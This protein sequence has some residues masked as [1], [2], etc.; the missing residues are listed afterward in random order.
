MIRSSIALVILLGLGIGVAQARIEEPPA[1][2]TVV[3]W[4]QIRALYE[5]HRHTATLDEDG[6]YVARNPKQGWTIRFDGRGFLVR[7]DE[8]DWT[9]GLELV[10]FGVSGAPQAIQGAAPTVTAEHEQVRYEWRPDLEE[11]FV[12]DTRGLEH[13]WTVKRR[14]QGADEGLELELAVRGGL[15]PEV[16]GPDDSAV[17]F[18]D[19]AG[20]AVV[21]YAGLKGW[22]ADGRALSS[23]MA[24]SAEGG[25]TILVDDREARYP[26]TVDP[27]AVQTAYIK[28]SNTGSIDRFGVSVSISGDTLAVGAPRED[29]NGV[30]VNPNTQADNSA[31]DSG[32][33]YVFQRTVGLWAQQAYIKASNTE[34]GDWFGSS[35]ALSGDTLVVG[36]PNED[37]AGNS[38]K[39]GGAVYLF[40]RT[41]ELWVQQDFTSGL[42]GSRFGGSVALYGDT[43]LNLAVGARYENGQGAVYVFGVAGG[44]LVG[45]KRIG[46]GGPGSQF[47][48]S[49]AL[50]ED[51]LAVGSPWGGGHQQGTV[52]IFTRANG[53]RQSATLIASN[54]DLAD[55]F[56]QSVAIDGDTLA[57]GAT[58]E[59][60][61]GVG[62][63]SVAQLNNSAHDSGAVYVF[64]RAGGLWVQQ[65]YVKASNPY[66]S[67]WFGS[68]V[69]LSGDTLA[70]G[71]YWEDSN[72]V[73]VN[74][75]AQ[76]GNSRTDSGAVYVFQRTGGLWVQ[77][78]FI[79]ASNTDAN[80]QF[81]YSIAL[82]VD[83]LVVGADGEDSNGV[84]INSGIQA[85]NSAAA[86]GA[87]YAFEFCELT[88]TAVT[89]VAPSPSFPG[90]SFQVYFMVSNVCGDTILGPVIVSNGEGGECTASGPLGS[91]WLTRSSAGV[92]TITATYEGDGFFL[93]S[94]GKTSHT[95]VI[96][97]TTTAGQLL[98]APSP[99]GIGYEVAFTVTSNFGVPT[100]SVMVSDGEASNTCLVSAGY[101]V[102][103]STTAGAK[104]ITIDYLGDG[105]FAP[106]SDSAAQTVVPVNTTTSIGYLNPSTPVA[107]QPYEVSYSI[108]S[109]GGVP[110]G[111]VTVS[112]GVAS[113]TCAVADPSC[114]LTT[115][116]AGMKTLTVSY[117][118]DG[119]FSPSSATTLLQV[120]D[121]SLSPAANSLTA[122]GG[123]GSFLVT[124]QD[125]CPWTANE[126]IPWVSFTSL[127][128]GQGN[129][130]IAYQVDPNAM[131]VARSGDITLI[132]QVH[133]VHQ[134]GVGCS[135]SISPAANSLDIAGGSGAIS[136]TALDG[137]DWTAT[138]V[139]PW[140]SIVSGASGSGNGTV[141]YTVD[142]NAGPAPRAGAITVATETHLV[143]QKGAGPA[144]YELGAF[145][146]GSWFLDRDGDFAF[147]GV[148]EIS[149]WGSPG[150]IPVDGDWNGDGFRDLGVFS[151]GTWFIDR[152]GDTAFDPAT[153]IQG[154][155]APG[156]IPVTGDWNGDGKTDVGVVDP[157]TST[158]FLDLNG[159]FAFDP[160]T[161]IRGWGSPGDTPVVG[162][163]DG[164]G[165]DD[166]GVFSGGTWFIDFNGDGGF[167]LATDQRGWG[168]AGWIPVVGDWDGDGADE[169]G[170]IEP[171]SMAWFR[172]V[173]GDFLF[174]PA[175]ELIGWG[176]P[177]D[178]PVVADWNGDGADDVG[179][180]S[181]GTWFIDAAGDGAFDPATDIRGWGVAGWTPVPGAW[182]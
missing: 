154:W 72:G 156:W 65:A 166:I 85:D 148:S 173:N 132:D 46:Q 74:P 62:V 131:A 122:A 36:A 73:G 153:E 60:S 167:Q 57:V 95:V 161:E 112:D 159:D 130:A 89:R 174:D 11:W 2:L 109:P 137:C 119:N 144:P 114:P 117:L 67:D 99:A 58:G 102:L 100:G 87:V 152:N 77:Q 31:T 43:Y 71:A 69:A 120:C 16:E 157:S 64:H 56:G 178:T 1:G 37:G 98:P 151:N 103:I 80:D 34:A 136:V 171:T 129:G 92:K 27:V 68:S 75:N 147:D 150:D 182:Q 35:V 110:T 63:D 172:D 42:Q 12:N 76:S 83:T 111:S 44:Q 45:K 141:A 19:E 127:Q 49:V 79:K 9:W 14:P 15:R 142:A 165:D 115:A 41:G 30:G 20:A 155:G 17:R 81:S 90:E 50:S 39:E 162:D 128:F 135:Y 55:R 158:W 7:P 28:A 107:G 32:A 94:S 4:A 170:A 8:G 116:T 138:E 91:C 134:E 86:S 48:Q 54:G 101:C 23:R 29:S 149:G 84:G 33:V 51:T 113:N 59:S 82:S 175:T 22:D 106:S 47:G 13:G 3:D 140:V 163:W 133:T 146:N 5:R 164:D 96:P 97:T 104:I 176:S 25:L 24:V 108:I 66:V 139:L 26:V 10:G 179:V 168:V 123:S 52:T 53:W 143:T 169:I 6:A 61:N 145:T 181:G 78:A 105:D 38:A 125:G 93:P 88:T 21:R 121:Y 177:G 124:T 70:V 180:F 18:V 118:G 40:Q 126:A 160:A